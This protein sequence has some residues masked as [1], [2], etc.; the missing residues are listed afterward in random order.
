MAKAL[1]AKSIENLRPDAIRR[2]IADGGCRGLFFIIQPSG[3]RSWACRYRIN[4]KS[5]KLTLGAFPTVGLPQARR[6][7][8]TALEQLAKGGNPGADKRQ[9]KAEALERSKDTVERLAQQFLEEYARKKTRQSSW[10]AAERTLLNEAAPAWRGRVVTDIRRRDVIELVAN[11]ARDRPVQAN[12]ACAHL[13]RFFRWLVARDV[14]AGSPCIGV[15]RPGTETIRER[16]LSDD[17]ICRFWNAVSQL[18]APFPD[19]YR[20]LLL[21]GQR[22][23]EVADMAWNELDLARRVWTLPATRAKNKVTHLLPLGPLAWEIIERQPRGDTSDLVFGPRRLRDLFPSAKSKLDAIM[24]PDEPWVN[25][26]LRRTARSLLARARVMPDIA[27]LMLGHLLPGMRRVYD[28]HKYLDEK[29]A[30]FVALEREID[31]I[32][33]PPAAEVVPLRR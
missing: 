19:V 6:L 5:Q 16:A 12:R 4:G 25:H 14:I 8:A 3:A 17:E 15:E 28:K 22:K 32:L 27:E 18:P 20:L 30:G 24:Q 26:D 11:I 31:L 29:R 13:S 9:A 23:Q 10:R 21:T 33:N 2:E 7:A 1:T